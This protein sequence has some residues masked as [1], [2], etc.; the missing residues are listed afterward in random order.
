M[1]DFFQQFPRIQKIRKKE[2]KLKERWGLV[3]K[4]KNRSSFY[5]KLVFQEKRK[6]MTE[7]ASGNNGVKPFWDEEYPVAAHKNWAKE[8]Q[9]LNILWWNFLILIVNKEF[10]VQKEKVVRTGWS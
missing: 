8:K 5:R 1:K 4:A 7:Q 2:K 9:H 3:Q 6:K 10:S